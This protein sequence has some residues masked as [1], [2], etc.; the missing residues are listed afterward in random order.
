MSQ[1]SVC[2]DAVFA[3]M[4]L[5]EAIAA[6]K[7]AG[8]PAIEFWGWENK[9][10]D[11]LADLCRQNNL[12]VAAMCTAAFD[13]VDPAKR[14]AYL[15]GLRRSIPMAQKLGCKTLITQVGA[16]LPRP[17]AEQHDSIVA[18]LQAC[19]PL[20]EAAGITLVIEPLN[21]RVDHAGYYLTGSDEA[22]EIIRQVGSPNVKMLFDVY[23]QQ[24]TEGDV[25]R[26]LRQHMDCIGHFHTAG[27]PGRNELYK[28]E[29]NYAAVFDAIQAT[30]YTGYVGLEYTPT[31]AVEQGLGYAVQMM[32]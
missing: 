12:T 26:H 24:I 17:R 30:G 31:D 2:I 14:P 21:I 20:L 25:I 8:I 32:G 18:G 9:D 1:L 23:H 4:P 10:I 19:A 13:L 22:A 29:V 11:L 7:A 6:V 3:G 16:A 5:P 15:D 27:N 28:G